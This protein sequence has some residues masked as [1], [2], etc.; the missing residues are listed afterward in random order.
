MEDK[1]QLEFVLKMIVPGKFQKSLVDRETD[2]DKYI[3]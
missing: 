1:E 3:F 2:F